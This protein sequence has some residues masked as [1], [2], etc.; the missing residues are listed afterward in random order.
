M[1]QLQIIEFGKLNHVK[2]ELLAKMEVAKVCE[3]KLAAMRR[4]GCVDCPL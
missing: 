1:D 3:G 4:C 2:R